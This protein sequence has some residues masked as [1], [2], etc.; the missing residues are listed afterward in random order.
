[1]KALP[2]LLIVATALTIW[3]QPTEQSALDTT[4]PP[5]PTG[6]TPGRFQLYQAT[7]SEPMLFRIDTATGKVWRYVLA[8]Y[9]FRKMGETTMSHMTTEGWL[10][11]PD[12]F[13]V[14]LSNTVR[15]AKIISRL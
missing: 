12:D 15:S 10:P 3:A 9:P 1:M 7:T 11:V 5:L 14:A 4:T 8:D 2:S 13:N 6:Q